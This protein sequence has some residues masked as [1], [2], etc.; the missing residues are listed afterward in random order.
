MQLNFGVKLFL[1]LVVFCLFISTGFCASS[2]DRELI[3]QDKTRA[4]QV[5]S[6]FKEMMAAY[7]D[8]DPRSF[9]DYVSDE[10]FRQDYITFTDALYSD[11]RNYEIHQV[12][13]WIDKVVPDNVKQ[14]LFV[15]WEKR[16]EN[17]DDGR[18][19]T[20][21]GVSR[22]LF[23]EV[24]GDY[25]LIELAGNQL[26]GAS[27][28]EWV[29]E[30]PPISG[31]ELTATVTEPGAVC[32]GQHLSLCDASNC[33]FNNGYWYDNSCHQ[34]PYSPSAVCDGQHLDLCSNQSECEDD[35]YGFWYDNTCNATAQGLADLRVEVLDLL[36]DEVYFRVYND[37]AVVSGSCT[38]RG[39]ETP[40]VAVSGPAVVTTDIGPIA[41]G[42]YVDGSLTGIWPPAQ[43]TI[44]SLDEVPESDE[45]N[46]Q[47]SYNY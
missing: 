44:D 41:A 2:Y 32:D 16:Y 24:E 33:A 25:L 27:L 34:T 11:F 15:R 22:F 31:Q 36:D 28:P 5:E 29:Q 13:Y 17:L 10:R 43:L 7:E 9:L 40:A 39:V 14:F 37:G 47:T 46:N 23:D 38:L 6:V 26:F 12:E 18:Q 4:M 19:L 45:Y 35:A 8:E 3:V 30:V 21:R 42:S 1:P 20:Q